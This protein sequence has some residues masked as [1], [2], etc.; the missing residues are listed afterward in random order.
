MDLEVRWVAV[1]ANV[2]SNQILGCLLENVHKTQHPHRS[3]PVGGFHP[4]KPTDACQRLFEDGF[5]EERRDSSPAAFF[6]ESPIH[7]VAAE[8]KLVDARY[9]VY[10]YGLEHQ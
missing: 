9:S 5:C 3:D 2:L 6:L 7:G 10:G 8:E 1:G 4:C